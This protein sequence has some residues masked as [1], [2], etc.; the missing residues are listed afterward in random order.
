MIGRGHRKGL[1]WAGN[2]LFLEMKWWLHGYLFDN[3][4]SCTFTFYELFSM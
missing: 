1:I 3:T 2:A 4:L